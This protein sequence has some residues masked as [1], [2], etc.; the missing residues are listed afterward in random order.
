MESLKWLKQEAARLQPAE[1]LLHDSMSSNIKRVCEGKRLLLF[2]SFVSHTLGVCPGIAEAFRKGFNITGWVEPSGLF[3]KDLKPMEYTKSMLLDQAIWKEK[4]DSARKGPSDDYDVLRAA[5]D[6]EVAAGWLEGPLTSLQLDGLFGQG[7][8]KSSLRFGVR[9]GLKVRPVDDY[10]ASGVNATVGLSEKV[11]L[12]SVDEVAGLLRSLVRAREEDSGVKVDDAW[13]AFDSADLLIGAVD[14]KA[15]YRQLPLSDDSAD[16]AII[17]IYNISGG[18]EYYIQRALPFGGASSVAHFNSWSRW[19]WLTCVKAGRVLW[20]NFYDDFP[21]TAP[22]VLAPSS[23][24]YIKTV[25]RLLGVL[26][27]E[28]GPKSLEWKTYA[29]LLGVRISVEKLATEG[30]VVVTNKPE[31]VV[32]LDEAIS[33][34]LFRGNMTHAEAASLR[35]RLGFAE[36]QLFGREANSALKML[37]EGGD[38]SSTRSRVPLNEGLRKALI[39]IRERVVLAVPRTISCRPPQVPVVLFTDGACEDVFSTSHGAVIFDP[40]NSFKQMFG[41]VV[42]RDVITQWAAGGV[43]QLVGQAEIIPVVVSL[44]LWGSRMRGRLLL[45]FVDNE[46][47]KQ[48]LT[49]CSSPVVSSQLLLDSFSKG[50]ALLQISPW[51]TRVPSSS[52]IGDDPSRLCFDVLHG[53]GYTRVAVPPLHEVANG[54]IPSWFNGR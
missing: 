45:V 9:Q 43:T 12:M 8:W 41:G 17:R 30:H 20:T 2:D 47:A 6:K 15:A 24:V 3:E 16:V 36:G 51:F 42:D 19:I 48:C 35:G 28:E 18:I 27:D 33:N 29:D 54:G 23:A 34:F 11:N 32:E 26:F 46:S 52:N 1:D 49:S 38:S 31:R 50:E 22:R 39:V 4:A 53:L 14:L 13:R 37:R 5:C 21:V 25:L 7:R 44:F 40:V 10:S